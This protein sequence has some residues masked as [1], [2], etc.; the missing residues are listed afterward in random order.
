MAVSRLREQVADWRA[1]AEFDQSARLLRNIALSG[2]ESK[3]GYRYSES[4]LRRAARLYDQKP[5]FLDHA[6]QAVE[7]A[8][9]STRD[10]VGS[11][12]N[13]RF[14]AGRLRGDVRVLETESGRTFLALVE[15]N[16][17]GV[18]MSHVV[19]AQ[20]S[21]DGTTVERIEDVISVDVVVRPA[22][23]STFRE[24][25][26]GPPRRPDVDFREAEEVRE[27]AVSESAPPGPGSADK[28]M[29][30]EVLPRLVSVLERVE[31]A[32]EKA[33][34]VLAAGAGV[35]EEAHRRRDATAPAGVSLLE[36]MRPARATSSPRL[37]GGSGLSRG[38]FVAAVRGR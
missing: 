5:V 13:P 17:P 11:I 30:D 3:N 2:C 19:L 31:A 35:Q 18:G 26:D 28:G 34:G 22:T 25:E 36:R 15:G 21:V 12:V 10:L 4:A 24:S 16:T 1:V 7:A 32:L 23:T 14:D 29:M 6:G 37:E 33:G 9:R 38:A 20:R 8:A 27:P